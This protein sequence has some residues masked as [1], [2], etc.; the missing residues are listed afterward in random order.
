[1]TLFVQR[2]CP[3]GKRITG[4]TH[5]CK[6]CKFIYGSNP[7]EWPEWLRFL[8]NDME[9]DLRR[10]NDALNHNV[11]HSTELINNSKTFRLNGCRDKEH[12]YQ[13]RSK[14]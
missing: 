4:K 9:R 6:E 5:L 1:M 13:D 14:Y 3:C 12:L 8:V 7:V 2:Y 11:P 10:E